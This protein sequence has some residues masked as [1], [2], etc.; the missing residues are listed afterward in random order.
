MK[1]ILTIITLSLLANWTVKTYRQWQFKRRS[2]SRFK[3]I[4]AT[5]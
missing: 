5:I 4:L 1:T 2:D 3:M